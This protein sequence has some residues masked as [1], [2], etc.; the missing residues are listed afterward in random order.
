MTDRNYNPTADNVVLLAND[1]KQMVALM[2]QTVE[3]LGKLLQATPPS[4]DK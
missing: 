2:A 4:E 1:M 3:H